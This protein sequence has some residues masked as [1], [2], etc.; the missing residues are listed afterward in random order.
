MYGVWK[1][2]KQRFF[3]DQI[4][5]KQR[6][7]SAVNFSLC[8]ASRLPEPRELRSWTL[9]VAIDARSLRLDVAVSIYPGQEFLASWW[10]YTSLP[11]TLNLDRTF[12]PS[13]VTLRCSCASRQSRFRTWAQY[14][15]YLRAALSCRIIRNPSKSQSEA[16]L[17][18]PTW[19]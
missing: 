7:I 12:V 14:L 10:I 4:C 1:Y 3:F 15:A 17:S 13:G 19:L 18:G 11:I 6:R 8:C 2:Q 9:V 5:T 16:G